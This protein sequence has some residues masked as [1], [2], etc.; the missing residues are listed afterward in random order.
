MGPRKCAGVAWESCWTPC[1]LGPMHESSGSGGRHR[2][3][4]DPG[5]SRLGQLVDPMGLRTRAPVA[6]DS[7]SNPRAQGR[8]RKWPGTA[9]QPYS[10]LDPGLSHPGQQVEPAGPRA[11]ARLTPESYST[12][13]AIRHE[14]DTHWRAGRPLGNGTKRESP[15]TDGRPRRASDPSLS[16]PGQ[17]VDPVGLRAWARVTPESY[18]TLQAFGHERDMPGSAGS[19]RGPLDPGPSGP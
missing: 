16:R 18:L 10:P 11:R 2:R 4:S 3:P 1:D 8:K 14:R 17:L 5:L 6:Q 13:R 9:G 7:W 12:P 19:T 15:G